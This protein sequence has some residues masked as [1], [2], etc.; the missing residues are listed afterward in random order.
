[1]DL[2]PVLL[3]S[4]PGLVVALPALVVASLGERNR[5]VDRAADRE[6]LA[7]AAAAEQERRREDQKREAASGRA[8]ASAAARD[9]RQQVFAT[10]VIEAQKAITLLASA[11]ANGWGNVAL[12]EPQ[13]TS[14]SSALGAVLAA[15]LS[16][17]SQVEATRLRYAARAVVDHLIAAN[18]AF[19]SSATQAELLEKARERSHGCMAAM[20]VI[21]AQSSS[22]G[23]H[24]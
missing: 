9:A 10:F 4:I 22:P 7:A 2:Q 23:P 20:Y 3:S 14:L 11:Q 13:I 19:G 1:M 18:A 6:Q 17:G 21:N 15:D 8:A 24:Q 12:L 5:R 16:E